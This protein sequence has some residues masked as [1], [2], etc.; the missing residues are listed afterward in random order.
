MGN[1][2]NVKANKEFKTKR[3]FHLNKKEYSVNA[4]NVQAFPNVYLESL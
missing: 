2:I 3:L 1:T 4:K